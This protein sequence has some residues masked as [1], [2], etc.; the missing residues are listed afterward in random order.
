MHT[1]WSASDI[2][3]LGINSELG[4]QKKLTMGFKSI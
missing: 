1:T 2:N 4:P 3:M